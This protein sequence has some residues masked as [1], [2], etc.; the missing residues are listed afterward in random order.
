MFALEISFQDGVSQPEMHFI[1]RPQALIGAS[2][3]AHVVVEDMRELG[4]QIRLVRDLGSSFRCNLIGDSAAGAEA[5]GVAKSLYEGEAVLSTGPVRFVV[6]ALDSDLLLRESETPDK[7]GVRVMRAA[8]ALRQPKFPAV[9]VKGADPMVISFAP[10]HPVYLGRSKLCAVRFD[11]ADISGRHARIG[12]EGGEFWIE[13]LGST[14]GT[15]VNDQQISGRENLTQ[16]AVV[17]LGRDVSLT[18]VTSEYQIDYAAEEVPVEIE[19]ENVE[20][21]YPILLSVSGVARPAKVVVKPGDFISIG[22]DPSSEMWLGAPHVSRRHC[23]VSMKEEGA[24]I[25]TDYST[26][27]TGHEDGILKSGDYLDVRGNPK[28]LNFGGGITVA[29]CFSSADEEEFRTSNGAADIFSRTGE[30]SS[31]INVASTGIVKSEIPL[32]QDVG[33]ARGVGFGKADKRPGGIGNFFLSLSMKGKLF[34][35]ITISLAVGLSATIGSLLFSM[36]F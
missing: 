1:R 11:S 8:C 10:K 28:V 3:F 5:A 21:A 31:P 26:N 20:S 15:F 6:T 4:Y 22:R 18:A 25:V 13:D 9:V 32:S 24:L 14:N 29:L 27:G 19:Q 23:V 30:S 16:G 17:R 2:E 12:V 33:S 34:L 36:K 35:L 7:A